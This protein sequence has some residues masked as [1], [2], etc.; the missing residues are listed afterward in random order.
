MDTGILVAPLKTL[1]GLFSEWRSTTGVMCM[2]TV[3][4]TGRSVTSSSMLAL[5]SSGIQASSGH[6]YLSHETSLNRSSSD[7]SVKITCAH[8]AP[9]DT[10]NRSFSCKVGL[11]SMPTRVSLIVPRL[12]YGLYPRALV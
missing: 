11:L 3:V 12:R 10:P 5:V 7:L 6:T 4:S 2:S 9:D 8:T 1:A